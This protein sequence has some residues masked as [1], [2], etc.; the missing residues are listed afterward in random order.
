MSIDNH[1]I[2]TVC[3]KFRCNT[4]KVLEIEH[5][6][7]D[8]IEKRKKTRH[9]NKELNSKIIKYKIIIRQR[10]EAVKKFKERYPID[11]DMY[12]NI[13]QIKIWENE[14]NTYSMI[15]CGLIK[16]RDKRRY[17]RMSTEVYEKI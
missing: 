3:L 15:L 11:I 17:E 12:S 6:K 13:E 8:I 2:N 9:I 5:N 16:E 10:K 4:E 7:N 1:R 14:I